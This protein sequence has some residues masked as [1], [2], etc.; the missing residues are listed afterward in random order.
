MGP[1]MEAKIEQKLIKT[2]FEKLTFFLYVL[3]AMLERFWCENG[4]KI[5]LKMDP[6][7]DKKSL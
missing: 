6:K 5:H 2:W 1:K 4:D 3:K 7:I